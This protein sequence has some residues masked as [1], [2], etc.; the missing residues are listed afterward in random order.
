MDFIE[1]NPT[2]AVLTNEVSNHGITWPEYDHV[3]ANNGDLLPIVVARIRRNSQPA[4]IVL[5]G[6]HRACLYAKHERNLSAY[7]MT[8][9]T[10][11]TEILQMEDTTQIHRFPHREFVADE[12]SFAQLM[13]RAIK[14]ALAI[15]ETISQALNRIARP[16]PER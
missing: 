4:Y 10:T 14:A 2:L 1:F 6:N 15:D 9:R 3:L 12:E 5:D 8:P 11:S 13:A 7:V 16:R